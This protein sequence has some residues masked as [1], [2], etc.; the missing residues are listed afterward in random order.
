MEKPPSP[1]RGCPRCSAGSRRPKRSPR[2]SSSCPA[3]QRYHPDCAADRRRP[4]DRL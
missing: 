4:V 3:P 1:P 2:W